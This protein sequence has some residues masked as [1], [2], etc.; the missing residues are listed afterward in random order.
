MKYLKEETLSSLILHVMYV[1]INKFGYVIKYVIKVILNY[2]SWMYIEYIIGFNS[3]NEFQIKNTAKFIK[4][5]KEVLSFIYENDIVESDMPFLNKLVLINLKR[6]LNNE[7]ITNNEMWDLLQLPSE[8]LILRLLHAE[9]N[10]PLTEIP[11]LTRKFIFN[12]K[13]RQNKIHKID[14]RNYISIIIQSVTINKN[15]LK[16][17]GSIIKTLISKIDKIYIKIDDNYFLAKINNIDLHYKVWGIDFKEEYCFS[18]N[19]DYSIIIKKQIEFYL[20]IDGEI[21]FCTPILNLN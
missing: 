10:L 3:Y 8:D 5:L 11:E 15:I 18:I 17:E 19:L 1:S 20:E 7:K 6:N 12:F 14:I 4:D 21:E 13:N 9:Y 2:L 16:I